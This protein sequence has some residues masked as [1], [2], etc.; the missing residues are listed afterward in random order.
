VTSQPQVAL[1]P[2]VTIPW[3]HTG[4]PTARP[5]TAQG[6][7]L[8]LEFGHFLLEELPAP[9]VVAPKARPEIA[10]GEALGMM[11][12]NRSRPIG[13]TLPRWG[14]AVR[15]RLSTQGFALGFFRSHLW[16]DDSRG[17]ASLAPGYRLASLRDAGEDRGHFETSSWE[18]LRTSRAQEVHQPGRDT[19]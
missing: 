5:K 2:C 10:Q 16:C 18:V 17:C 11:A 14:V 19:I 15:P 4:A 8:G 12:K 7:A 3:A 9:E 6:E 1:R 13:P